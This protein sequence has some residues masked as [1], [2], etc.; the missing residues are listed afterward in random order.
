M[1]SDEYVVSHTTAFCNTL[2]HTATHCSTLQHTS[3]LPDAATRCKTLPLI[4]NFHIVTHTGNTLLHTTAHYNILSGSA[5][6]C[7]TLQHTAT[8]CNTLQHTDTLQHTATHC[9][10]LS[11]TT[12][13]CHTA[14]HC[15]TLPHI[16]TC[17]L[18]KKLL[19]SGFSTPYTPF[20]FVCTISSKLKCIS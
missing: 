18:P 14:L 6:H 4:F 19:G 17:M 11:Y 16:H 5:A 10:A 9:N 3:I 8:H 15:H 1:L 13:D 20:C 2:Q 7:N 12:T